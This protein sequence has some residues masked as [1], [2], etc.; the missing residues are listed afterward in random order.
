[1]RNI[2]FTA[3][4][5]Y[6]LYVNNKQSGCVRPSGQVEPLGRGLSFLQPDMINPFRSEADAFRLLV[7]AVRVPRR[8]RDRCPGR[9]VLVRAPSSHWHPVLW[10]ALSRAA[11]E[12]PQSPSARA[13]GEHRVANESIAA[14]PDG[15]T[16]RVGGGRPEVLVCTPALNSRLRYWTSDEDVPR[17]CPGAARREP[18]ATSASAAGRSLRRGRRRQ[19]PASDRGRAPNIGPGRDRRLRRIR[20]DAGTGWN[21]G[22]SSTHANDSRS[23][24]RMSSSTSTGSSR[25]RTTRT[26]NGATGRV[27]DSSSVTADAPTLTRS[28]DSRCRG[29]RK[30]RRE[31]DAAPSSRGKRRRRARPS[32]RSS[33]RSGAEESCGYRTPKPG[34]G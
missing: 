24:S 13:E 15:R 25:K 19:S 20:R 28:Y 27:S 30:P 3:T 18:R 8:D 10:W 23:R 26:G 22:S 21:A 11:D 16:S 31:Q 14:E 34:S 4:A 12:P 2:A 7:G 1:M 5:E 29:Q 6:P 33:P 9:R 32:S 17:G